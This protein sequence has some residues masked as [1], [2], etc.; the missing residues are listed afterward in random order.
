[1]KIRVHDGRRFKSRGMAFIL[2]FWVSGLV[3]LTAQAAP[4][5]QTTDSAAPAILVRGPLEQRGLPLGY[6][7]AVPCRYGLYQWGDEEIRVYY[8][9]VELELGDPWTEFRCG[10]LVM[11]QREID[12]GRPRR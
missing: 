4:S 3:G 2:I 8:S 10:R 11:R 5:G 9:D 6:A 12:Q 1:M 7:N